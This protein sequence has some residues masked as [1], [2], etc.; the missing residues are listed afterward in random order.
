MTEH[1]DAISLARYLGGAGTPAE[2]GLW[3]THLSECA[4]CRAEMIEARRIHATVPGRQRASL[5]PLA[6]AAAVLLVIWSGTATYEPF[7]HVTREP[8][9]A[10]TLALAPRPI[11]PLGN[12]ARADVLRWNAVPGVARYRA[13]LFTSE[14]Q[15]AWQT[16]TQDTSVAL[17]DTL[18][19]A[20]GT[21]YYWQVK[22]EKGFGRWV[23]SELVAFT[24]SRA[25]APR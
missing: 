9:G 24:I 22:A 8:E 2:T 18:R 6:A 12:T 13:T 7:K 3:E 25:D 1:L 11:A 5:V 10:A 14:G 17:P 15:P 4:D 16:T 23:G 21:P 19:L 20:A